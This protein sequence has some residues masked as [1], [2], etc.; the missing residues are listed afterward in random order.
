MPSLVARVRSLARGILTAALVLAVTAISAPPTAL[1]QA[2]EVL[3]D[4]P[5]YLSL[6]PADEA[7]K[8]TVLM[9]HGGG[10]HG[11]LGAAADRVM[12][13]YVELVRSWGY[14]V[15]NLGYRGGADSLTD[16]L[17]AFDHLRERLGPAEPI[18]LYGGSAGG[19]LALT[20][21]AKR[22]ASVDCVIDFLGPPDLEKWGSRPNSEAGRN[23]AVEAFG[24]ERLAELSPI[25]NVERIVSPVL[26]AAAPCD[27]YIEIEAQRDF[28]DALNDAGGDARFSLLRTGDEV[29]VSHCWVTANSFWAFNDAA[30]RFLDRAA[31]ARP[32]V[33]SPEAAS[34]EG[35]G[36]SGVALYAIAAVALL[37]GG[38]LVWYLRRDRAGLR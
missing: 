27:V 25:N 3:E 18:C 22:G 24:S 36:G 16:A 31:A 26:V 37:A 34:P 20:V 29:S 15:A 11:G 4:K 23:L 9:I 30:K 21:A 8:G 19:H 2:P 7:P 14:D 33:G 28:V 13:Q 35:D 1:A 5:Y 32:E 12:G 10:W 38:G 6:S 17:D